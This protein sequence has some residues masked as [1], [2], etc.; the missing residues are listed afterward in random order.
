[1]AHETKL[2][3]A[4]L[5][6]QGISQAVF[7][8]TRYSLPSARFVSGPFAQGLVSFYSAIGFVGY[9]RNALDCDDYATA[10]ALYMRALHVRSNL[11]TG[12]AFGDF[13]YLRAGE[14]HAI[15]A[16]FTVEGGVTQLKFFEPQTRKTV[17]LTLEERESC[18][19]FYL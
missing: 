7:S 12:I 16:F 17:E 14:G 3:R 5:Q 10:C 13:R 19:G 18:Q 6:G 15:C 8:D 9:A 1:M 11:R 4:F 2:L